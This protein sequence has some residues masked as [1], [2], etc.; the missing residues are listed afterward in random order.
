MRST[1]FG[2]LFVFIRNGLSIKQDRASGGLPIS[3]IETISHEEVD[4]S[5]V[6]FAGLRNGKL[7]DW[8][9]KSDDIL[10]SHINSYEHLGKCA[11]YRGVPDKLIHG[12]NLLCLRPDPRHA[13]AAYVV[14]LIRSPYFK[15]KL[16]RIINPSVNQVSVS[17]GNLKNLQVHLP[18]L[19]EQKRIAAI[20]DKADAL[21]RKRREAI[22]RLDTLLQSVFLEMFGDPV[23]NPRG[24]E[25]R[26]LGE[27]A[28][29]VGGGTPSRAVPAYYT[30]SICWA[31][32]KDMKG[33]VLGDTQEHI[34][35]EAIGRSATKLVPAGAI[36]VVVKSKILLRY[37]PVLISKVPVC[38]GQ[39][40][41]A[42]IPNDLPSRYIARHLRVGQ[43]SL[44][45]LARGVNTE[46]LTL[47][48][49]RNYRV[50]CPP[51]MLVAQFEAFECRYEG[52]R[53][54]LIRSEAG[55]N[56]LFA[57]LQRDVFDAR[58]KA[59]NQQP[60]SQL[61]LTFSS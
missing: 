43:Q 15:S 50:M 11:V 39:D 34:T 61:C 55:L 18:P 16:K 46:G 26:G 57:G 20:L 2:G 45:D 10:F 23:R 22:A 6:G 53:Q 56:N 12:M 32:S 17:V 58:P 30:G 21:R 33:D 44:L 13:D 35:E 37:L 1:A 19:P 27:V 8:L 41:K 36:L 48:H 28:T 3:R 14:H 60:S 54:R 42:I 9:L 51:P 59:H 40:L 25:T 38:F 29:F 49:L 52:Q 4:P 31:T 47:E 7:D 5:R 24:W